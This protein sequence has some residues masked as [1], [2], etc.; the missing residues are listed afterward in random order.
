MTHSIRRGGRGVR[1]ATRRTFALATALASS[2]ALSLAHA[3]TPVPGTLQPADATHVV[4]ALKASGVQIYVCKRDAANQ[5]TWSFQAPQADLYD[6]SG[7]L[8]VRHG[9]GP[10]WEA[11]DGSRITGKLL[12]HVANPD[13]GAAIP[14]LL[15]STTNAGAPGLLSKVRYVQRLATHGGAA[16]SQACTHEGEEGRSPYLA[17]YVFLE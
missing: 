8:V 13:D 14:M 9:A 2:A 6:A 16:P 11:P 7:Q 4:A 10:S 12:Q 5:L 15:L 1:L 17:E 3:Q